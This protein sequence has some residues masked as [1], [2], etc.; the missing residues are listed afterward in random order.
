V[1]W[2]IVIASVLAGG[3]LDVSVTPVRMT[4]VSVDSRRFCAAP[5]SKLDILLVIDGSP[6]MAQ[7]AENLPA[8]LEMIASLYD[9]PNS[10][11][12]Y[13]VAVVDSSVAQPG[14]GGEP[15]DGGRFIDTSCRAR[16][17][18]FVTAGG[19]E[20]DAADVRQAGCLDHCALDTLQTQPTITATDHDLRARPW[21]ES[22]S[23]ISNLPASRS[24]TDDLVCRA[25]VGIDGC[26]FEAPLEAMRL[27][28][29]RSDDPEDPAAGFLRDDAALF[30]L[31]IGDEPDCSFGDDLAGVARL[32]DPAGPRTYWSDPEADGPTSGMCWNAGVACGGDPQDLSCAAVDRPVPGGGAPVLRPVEAYAE[33]LRSIEARRIA[34]SPWMERAVFVSVLGGTGAEGEPPVIA[35][36][37][38]PREQAMFGIGPGCASELGRAYPPVRLGQLADEFAE[39]A[40]WGETSLFSVC[41]DEWWLALACLPGWRGFEISATCVDLCPADVS[42]QTETGTETFQHDCAVDWI[43]PDGQRQSLSPC[44]MKGNIPVVGAGDD[45][46]AHVAQPNPEEPQGCDRVS[47][48]PLVFAFA[49]GAPR[50]CFEVDCQVQTRPGECA[51]GWLPDADPWR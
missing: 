50:G 47:A 30:V 51:A 46:C 9:G 15:G 7:E 29:A 20:G 17:D 43:A 10:G 16:L 33:I 48:F 6:S 5:R 22:T 31:F 40:T 27:A 39:F 13:R 38:D 23:G 35:H 1:R 49:R 36:A 44:E 24:L 41:S 42:P 18:A 45:V 37:G 3:C 11:I 21:V 26:S 14:C 12:D 2:G 32:F 25:P 19:I 8:Q 4:T 34:R 28:L